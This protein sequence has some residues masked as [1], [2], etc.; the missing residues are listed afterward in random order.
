MAAA[1]HRA[2]SRRRRRVPAE[3][4]LTDARDT[5]S[6]PIRAKNVLIRFDSRYRID[7]FRFDSAI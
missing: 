6:I 2:P 5:A 7:F 3:L 1:R 4:L